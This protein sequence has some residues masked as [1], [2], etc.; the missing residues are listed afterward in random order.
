MT[1]C[2]QN[3][4]RYISGLFTYR[5]KFSVMINHW[6]GKLLD[7][8]DRNNLWDDTLLIM[9]T[10]HGFL[11]GEHKLTGKN[12]MHTYNEIAHPLLMIHLPGTDPDSN[13]IS[14]IT[15]KHRLD[16]DDPWLF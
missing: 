7:V 2:C 4:A 10:D 14:A 6:L 16:A 1:K 13:R 12:I 3:Q 5:I 9:T 11:L 8:M 15:Q